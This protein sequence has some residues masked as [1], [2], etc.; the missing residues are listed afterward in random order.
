L[1]NLR[2]ARIPGYVGQKGNEF[3]FFNDKAEPLFWC[4]IRRNFS[5]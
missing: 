1:R 2:A 5:L 4:H 3:H